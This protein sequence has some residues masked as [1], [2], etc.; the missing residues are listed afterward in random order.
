MPWETA[1]SAAIRNERSKP[2]DISKIYHT[3][4]VTVRALDS[5][6]FALYRGEIVVMLGASGS[7]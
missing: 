5:V 6:D 3:G 4:E 2:G 7:E 1:Q